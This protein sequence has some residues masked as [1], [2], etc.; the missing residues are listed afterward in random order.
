MKIMIAILLL[1]IISFVSCTDDSQV[2][3]LIT[4]KEI[5]IKDGFAGQS[6]T[7]IKESDEYFV[8]REYFGSGIPVIATSKYTVNFISANQIS[9]SE[10]VQQEGEDVNKNIREEFILSIDEENNVKLLLN[11]LQL[12]IDYNFD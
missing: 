7:L 2:L 11:G 6:I 10:V 12:V 4:N 8:V 9:F 5:L 3:D 1:F